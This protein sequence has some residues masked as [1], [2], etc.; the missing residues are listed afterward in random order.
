MSNLATGGQ[1]NLKKVMRTALLGI[2]PADQVMLKGYLRVLLRL[3]VD[4]EWVSANHPQ[5]DLFIINNEFRSSDSVKKLLN[6]QANKPVL[7]ATHSDNGEGWVAQDKIALPLKKLHELN[8]W[9][10]SHVSVLNS[11]AQKRVTIPEQELDMENRRTQAQ[12]SVLEVQKQS[13]PAEST[14]PRVSL[15]EQ[16]HGMIEL[17]KR[18]QQRSEGLYEIRNENQSIAII[19]PKK[20]ILWQK[21]PNHVSVVSL[22]WQ[23]VK[24]SGAKPEGM[25]AQDMNQWLWEHG[26][27]YSNDLLAL[28]SDDAYY[29]LRFWVKPRNSKDRRELLRLMTALESKPMQVADLAHMADTSVKTAKKV[30]AGLLLAGNLRDESY[31]DLKVALTHDLVGAGTQP[32]VLNNDIQTTQSPQISTIDSVLAR[33]KSGEAPALPTSSIE[34]KPDNKT[35]V[36]QHTIPAKKEAA[37]EKVGFLSRLRRKLGL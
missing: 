2:K 37:P 30:I 31:Q 35:S 21:D 11:K 1:S 7:Y 12:S 14:Q 26:W 10:M 8:D 23:L 17:I 25:I 6:Q 19:D 3:E 5:V 24:Y 34:I 15:E 33:R 9:L 36:T 32:V 20:A 29:H 16:Y 22:S 4:L 18:L 27:D 13:K 28:V